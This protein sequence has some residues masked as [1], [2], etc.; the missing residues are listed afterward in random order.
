MKKRVNLKVSETSPTINR[1]ETD[2]FPDTN[3]SAYV[4]VPHVVLRD[5]TNASNIVSDDKTSGIR[6]Q[7]GSFKLNRVT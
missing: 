5:I 4:G 7:T 6:T 1:S 3:M 2:M